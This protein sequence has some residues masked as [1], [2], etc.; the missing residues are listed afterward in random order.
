MKRLTMVMVLASALGMVVAAV[1]AQ[2]AQ[3]AP[4][5]PKKKPARPKS[6]QPLLR[7]AHAQ[8]AKVCDLSE[9][10]QKKIAEL[11]A[12]TK[13]AMKAFRTENDEKMREIREQL[14][15]ARQSKDKEAARNATTKLRA[16]Y[17]KQNEITKKS[18]AD[19]MAVLT[20]EQ[21]ATWDEYTAINAVK[22]WFKAAKLTDEQL[23]QIKAE[24]VKLAT[25]ADTGTEKGRRTLLAK[26]RE[27]VR[28]EILTEDQQTDVA[29]D[30]VTRQFRK[31]KLSDEQLAKVKAAYAKHMTAADPGKRGARQQAQKEL[32]AEIRTQILTAEQREALP[33]PKPAK[34]PKPAPKPKAPKE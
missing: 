11:N 26:L 4:K 12:K 28:K 3:E 22:G 24:Y 16:L 23:T 2:E 13:Q 5:K 25:G 10:Q 21:K 18:R 29:V 19:I 34:K 30:Q 6:K 9:D 33:K 32:M 17:A 7:G 14:R 27:H 15:K 31:V 1:A 20:P 8:M